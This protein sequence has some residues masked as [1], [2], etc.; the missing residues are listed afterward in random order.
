M[1]VHSVFW[2]GFSLYWYI[3]C[4]WGFKVFICFVGRCCFRWLQMLE[5]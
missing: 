4:V 3:T 1:T 5:K 2:K